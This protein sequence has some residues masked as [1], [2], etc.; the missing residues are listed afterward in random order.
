MR[1]SWKMWPI[2]CRGG[3]STVGAVRSRVAIAHRAPMVPSKQSPVRHEVVHVGVDL[4]GAGNPADPRRPAVDQQRS[5]E[6][7][8]PRTV[9]SVAPGPM[10]PGTRPDPSCSSVAGSMS[11]PG[12]H[13]GTEVRLMRFRS[14]SRSPAGRRRSSVSRRWSPS[15]VLRVTAVEPPPMAWRGVRGV[16]HQRLD[17]LGV[18]GTARR[19]PAHA[20]SRW[21]RHDGV[22]GLHV[23]AKPAETRRGVLADVTWVE[24]SSDLSRP[25]RPR[26]LARHDFQTEAFEDLQVGLAAPDRPLPPA[27]SIASRSP[28]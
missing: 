15:A 25:S 1:P 12:V 18:R 5:P 22:H 7:D 17:G 8:S 14:T 24:D 27:S 23:G 21:V 9:R 2:R 11:S 3:R 20:R 19:R 6:V 10:K 4:V 28:S 16:V 13:D 26:W